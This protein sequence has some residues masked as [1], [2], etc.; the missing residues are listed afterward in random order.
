MIHLKRLNGS[1]FVL[2]AEL[3]EQIESTPDTVITLITGNNIVVLQS[4]NDVIEKVLEYRRRINSE[5]N[6]LKEECAKAR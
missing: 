6:T 2:N 5:R 3:I 4:V 1:D